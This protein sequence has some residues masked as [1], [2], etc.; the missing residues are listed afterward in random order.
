MMTT[1]SLTQHEHLFFY[2]SDLLWIQKRAWHL[3]TLASSEILRDDFTVED[4][5]DVLHLERIL[6][7]RW[8]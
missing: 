4:G 5:Y 6:S 1:K 3:L 7:E 2:L 8:H